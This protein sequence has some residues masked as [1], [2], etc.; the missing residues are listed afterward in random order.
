MRWHPFFGC[1]II[2]EVLDVVIM[3]VTV[4]ILKWNSLRGLL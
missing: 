3:V 2:T 1:R 4:D